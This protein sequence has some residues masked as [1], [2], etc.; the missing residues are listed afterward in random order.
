MYT[1]VTLETL[2]GPVQSYVALC[3]YSREEVNTYKVFFCQKLPL[4][5]LLKVAKN[6]NI[7]SAV[8]AR[9]KNGANTWFAVRSPVPK[10]E[11]PVAAFLSF[12]L[13]LFYTYMCV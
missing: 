8:S 11:I 4:G 2:Q 10:V 3:G 6:S 1:E 13:A 5:N 12:L 7:K 9:N